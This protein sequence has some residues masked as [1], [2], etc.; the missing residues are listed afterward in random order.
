[1]GE[2]LKILTPNWIAYCASFAQT[3][4]VQAARDASG[5]SVALIKRH[6]NDR[7]V[8]DEVMRRMEDIIEIAQVD[9]ALLL[10]KLYAFMESDIIDIY[11]DN[12]AFKPLRE[13]PKVMRQMLVSFDLCPITHQPTKVKFLDRMRIIE[14][15][16]KHVDVAAFQENI[17]VKHELGE[18]LAARLDAG[19]RRIG[20]GV[21]Y[22]NE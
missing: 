1:M 19:R 10:R 7:I 11:Y 6:C 14:N 12:G 22:E 15:I 21:I 13:W 9:K 2:K 5:M 18:R 3:L 4:D 17:M 8:Q 20:E 16:G